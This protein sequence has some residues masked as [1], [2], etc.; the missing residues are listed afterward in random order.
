[1]SKQNQENSDE[2][3]VALPVEQIRIGMEVYLD[4]PW[5]LHPFS[6]NRFE[7]TSDTQLK[8]LYKLGLKEINVIQQ[9]NVQ[10]L[11]ENDYTEVTV[12]NESEE[13][14]Y[15]VQ[16]ISP[17][18]KKKQDVLDKK[19]ALQ[20]SNETYQQAINIVDDI[21]DGLTQSDIRAVR[22]TSNFVKIISNSILEDSESLVHFVNVK[23]HKEMLQF[24][25]L[26][27]SIIS[28]LMGKV[29]NISND[30]MKIL[31]MGALFHDIGYRNIPLRIAMKK[32][33]LSNAEQ[34]IVQQHCQYGYEIAS[35]MP[36]F[37]EE[38]LDI[39]KY[40][41][42]RID[43]SG[44]PSALKG[45]S[46]KFLTKIVA[47][48]DCYD[49]LAHVNTASKNQLPHVTLSYMY[50]NMKNKFP[51]N[52]IEV[53]IKSVGVYPP[54]SLVELN[55][56][57]VGMVISVNHNSTIK[58]TV[59]VFNPDKPRLEPELVDLYEEKRFSIS[60][61]LTISDLSQEVRDYLQPGRLAGYSFQTQSLQEQNL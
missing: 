37:P 23:K 59:M 7:I 31:G 18:S 61:A 45:E 22:K 40:H 30:D 33:N 58:P 1:M 6:K 57:R 44:Y 56:G 24:H 46:I 41:H 20:R 50:K 21:F 27:V 38:A 51:V 13:T 17:P 39:V 10:S 28:L 16:A 60:R 49:N 8:K 47:I 15:N 52:L 19:I 4:I 26:N 12:V 53:L 5:L 29:A 3:M 35:Q 42:E 43:G 32:E 9:P 54:G 34:E 36:D 11:A 25:S 2:I 55:D 48:A 14:V